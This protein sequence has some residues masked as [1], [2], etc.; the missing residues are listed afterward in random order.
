LFSSSGCD[1]QVIAGVELIDWLAAK[2]GCQV[3]VANRES[4][5]PR[6][7]LVEDL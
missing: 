1:G 4:L 7:E 2:H 6:Q 3:V 5:S